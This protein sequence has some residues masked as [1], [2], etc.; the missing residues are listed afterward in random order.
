MFNWI[1][2]QEQIEE[3]QVKSGL[4]MLLYDGMCSQVMGALTGGAILVAFALLLGASNTVIGLIAALAPLTQILQIPA[5]YLV[6][7]T[8]LRKF[9]VV[10]S[11]FLVALVK[12]TASVQGT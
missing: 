8:R 5:L 1:R 11:S 6:E 4:Q 7:R 12:V 10:A 2:P 9:L 3:H